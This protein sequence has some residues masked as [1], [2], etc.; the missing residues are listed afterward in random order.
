MQSPLVSIIIPTYNRANFLKITLESIRGQTF[1][2]FEIIVVDDG[3]PN[4]ANEQLCQTFSK[5]LYIKIE[6]SGGPAKPR[7]IGIQNANGKYLAFVDDDDLWLPEKLAQQVAILEGNLDFGLVH[8]CCQIIDEKGNIKP[9]IIGRPGSP[10]V[11]HGDVSMQMIGN[12]GV[13]MPTS[14]VR[15]KVIDKVGFFN[16]NMPPAGEDMEYWTRCSFETKFYYLDEPL[17]LYRIHHGNIS[18]NSVKY[19]DL[20]LYLK[21]VAENALFTKKIDK[22]SFNLLINSICQ[23][24]IRTVKGNF[25]K[26][27]KNLFRLNHFWV[28]GKNNCKMIL[29]VLFLKKE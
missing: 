27:I 15:K 17:V 9:E 22:K 20:P 5:V 1:Q 23:F 7:N 12:W 3:T 21:K 6:N 18:S 2:D 10:D 25:I 19:L 24:Q 16:E 26:T 13:M 28:L 14:F 11:K 29:Y 4:D 8:G